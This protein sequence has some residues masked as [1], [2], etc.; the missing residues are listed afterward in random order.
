[1][2]QTNVV[3]VFMYVIV[4]CLVWF[5]IALQGYLLGV[6]LTTDQRTLIV[7]FTH[8]G[9]QRKTTP[10]PLIRYS[11]VYNRTEAYQSLEGSGA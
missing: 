2:E 9:A 7:N 5:V 4:L 8:L 11:G 10:E 1:M 3:S 6:S